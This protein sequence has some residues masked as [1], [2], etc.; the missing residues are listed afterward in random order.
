[1]RRVFA[2][3]LCILPA[4]SAADDLLG[5]KSDPAASSGGGC[6]GFG[7]MIQ[8]LVAL[9]IVLILLKV[10]LPK[11]V[12]KFGK[13]MVTTFDGGIKIEES[14]NF[15]GGTLYVVKARKK[16]L[17][18][19]VHSAGVT[20]LSD[21]TETDSLAEAPTFQE[22]VDTAVVEVLPAPKAGDP[23]FALERLRRFTG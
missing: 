16:T 18:L 6:V 3:I 11:L 12:T 10:L 13:K 20:C 23:R 14:A 22:M 7:P 5:T 21:L 4:L 17:L 15:A 8:M 9:G 2:L 19:S 1:M